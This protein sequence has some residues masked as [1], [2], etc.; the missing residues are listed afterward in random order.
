[1]PDGPQRVEYLIDSINCSD[2]TLQATIG[3]IRVNTNNMRKDSE[4]VASSLI[5]VDPYK[6]Q[7]RN[8]P[9]KEFTVFG[10]F[11]AGRGASSVYLRW[12]HP[13]ESKTLSNDK[14]D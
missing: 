7:Q 6:R 8:T 3:L 1:M 14:K 10:V 4:V 9:T 13:K 5:E 12:H 11:F 2:N